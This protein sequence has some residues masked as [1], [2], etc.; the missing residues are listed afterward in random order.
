[1]AIVDVMRERLTDSFD[2]YRDLAAEIPEAS[3]DLRLPGLPS[4]AVGDQLWCVVG[5]R[6]S[7]T[8]AIESGTWQGFSCSLTAGDTRATDAVRAGL[9]RSAEG[10]LAAIV[11]L[12]SDDDTRC[13]FVL[14]LLEHEAAHHGQ[15]IRYLYGLR[16]PIPDRWKA[17]Y[18]LD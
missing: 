8:R 14:R 2:L 16:L 10:V 4:N 3:L 13:R 5:A 17:R 1:M 11:D 6:E 9:A 15:L 12:D 18:A 7:F